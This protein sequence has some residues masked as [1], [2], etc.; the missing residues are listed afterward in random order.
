[1]GI[2]WTGLSLLLIGFVA[3]TGTI[4]RSGNSALHRRSLTIGQYSM[5][6]YVLIAYVMQGRWQDTEKYLSENKDFFEK[7]ASKQ[8]LVKKELDRAREGIRLAEKKIAA[9]AVKFLQ[10]LFFKI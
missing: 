3:E 6:N 4:R 2:I 10:S 7:Q 5:R 1:M 9:P 8:P